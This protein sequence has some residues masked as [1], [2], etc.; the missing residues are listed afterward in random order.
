MQRLLRANHFG[1]EYCY[2]LCLVLIIVFFYHHSIS[3]QESAL[4]LLLTWYVL[5]F[6]YEIVSC[7]ILS[8]PKILVILR[9]N[10]CLQGFIYD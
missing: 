2:R 6:F 8:Y 5:G 1:R 10:H 4:F 3:L 7:H 9:D